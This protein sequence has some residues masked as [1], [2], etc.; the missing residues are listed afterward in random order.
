MNWPGG[1]P[2]DLQA[3]CLLTLL[4]YTR[5]LNLGLWTLV[6]GINRPEGQQGV[7][8]SETGPAWQ[9]LEGNLRTRFGGFC[10]EIRR[11]KIRALFKAFTHH[12][13]EGEEGQPV[14]ITTPSS[15]GAYI[16][17]I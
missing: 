3:P 2:T 11:G 4:R 6:E 1:L 14:V 9:Q 12:Q 7:N 13:L 17:L 16:L 5:N 15:N 8:G 10:R